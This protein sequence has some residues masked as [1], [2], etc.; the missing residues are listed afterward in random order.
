MTPEGLLPDSREPATCLCSES[1]QVHNLHT[2][3]WKPISILFY[4]L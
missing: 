1:D 2:I 3:S 4:Y